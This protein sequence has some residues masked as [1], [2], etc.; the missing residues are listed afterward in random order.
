MIARAFQQY[1][2]LTPNFALIDKEYSKYKPVERS[3]YEH[4]DK[5]FRQLHLS[6]RFDEDHTSLIKTLNYPDQERQR[7]FD[8]LRRNYPLRHESL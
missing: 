1:S 7:A 5:L 2:G 3:F 6:R 4:A 8:M